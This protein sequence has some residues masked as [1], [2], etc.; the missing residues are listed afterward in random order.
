MC[1]H[2]VWI[3]S[4]HGL[5]DGDQLT[6]VL[7]LDAEPSWAISKYARGLKRCL[8]RNRYTVYKPVYYIIYIYICEG[9]FFH[10]HVEIKVF[11][12][13]GSGFLVKSWSWEGSV[14]FT[15]GD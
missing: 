8:F 4:D 14:E 11:E 9:I 1:H 13:I 3:L 2:D 15:E 5:G 10:G 6:L 7:T 12:D